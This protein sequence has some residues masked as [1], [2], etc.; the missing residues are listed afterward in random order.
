MTK[1]RSIAL[2]RHRCRPRYMAEWSEDHMAAIGHLILTL[3]LLVESCKL[4]TG[5]DP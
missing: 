3:E 5:R 4:E 1:D 2:A